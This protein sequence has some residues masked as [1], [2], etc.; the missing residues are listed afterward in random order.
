MTTFVGRDGERTELEQMLTAA[1]DGRG[2]LALL[3][4]EPGIGK[5]TLAE[6]VATAATSRG[7]AVR[8]GRC[9][10][11]TGAPPFWPFRPIVQS[12]PPADGLDRFELFENIA[13]AL[14]NDAAPS[15]LVVILDDL[16]WADEGTL[17]LLEHIAVGLP[18]TRLLIIGTYRDVDVG[19]GDP[20]ERA[21]GTLVR[22]ATQF[23]LRG[24]ARADV[25]QLAGAARGNEVDPATVSA[26]VDHTDGNPF[27]L[28]QVMRLLAA[29]GRLEGVP[30]G[31]GEVVRRRLERLG[32][33]A[34]GVLTVAAVLGRGFDARLVEALHGGG[35]D[36]DKAI[37]SAVDAAL[38]E[39]DGALPGRYRFVHALVRE[40]LYED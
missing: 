8:W 18:Q 4:G 16:H 32:D 24:L 7:A 13:A 22:H 1:L 23:K 35:V 15:G 37:D 39:E 14:A 11:A 40:V 2:A 9:P 29:E 34:V 27:F 38:L 33:D 5:T 19:R 12:W 30:P 28:N 25:A 6:Q 10:E 17:R 31:V 3:A 36:V 21:L 26:L 20:L